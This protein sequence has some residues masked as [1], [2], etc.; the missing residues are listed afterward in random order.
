MPGDV[1]PQLPGYLGPAIREQLPVAVVQRRNLLG[2]VWLQRALAI[3][4]RQ[5]RVKDEGRLI[6]GGGRAVEDG[7]A[8]DR[9]FI[10]DADPERLWP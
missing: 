10:Q 4:D 7:D 2:Q 5:P 8:G 9:F 6:S 3:V 1:G